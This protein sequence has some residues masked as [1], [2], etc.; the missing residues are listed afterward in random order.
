MNNLIYIHSVSNHYDISAYIH[1]K[2]YHLSLI[3]FVHLLL[4]LL[5]LLQ[6]TNKTMI[7]ISAKSSFFCHTCVPNS[8]EKLSR[9]QWLFLRDLRQTRR[10]NWNNITKYTFWSEKHTLHLSSSHDEIEIFSYRCNRPFHTDHSLKNVNDKNTK[11]RW[12]FIHKEN[13]I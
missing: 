9:F 12:T 3:H 8:I 10:A 5:L 11:N 2:K 4:L 7:F 1:L 6:S 13:E